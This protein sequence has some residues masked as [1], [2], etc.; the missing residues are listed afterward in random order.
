MAQDLFIINLVRYGPDSVPP[1]SVRL[2]TMTDVKNFQAG[3]VLNRAE[4]G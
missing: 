4:N 1:C 2:T 3:L